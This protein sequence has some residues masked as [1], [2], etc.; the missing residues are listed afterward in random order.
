MTDQSSDPTRVV[1]TR[2]ISFERGL[3][4]VPKHFAR[5]GDVL[6]SH[7]W[8]ML[9]ASFPEGE[10]FFVRSVR[11]YRDQITDP[12]LKR[13]VNGFIGQEASHAREHRALNDRLAELGYP[14]KG[15][16]RSQAWVNRIRERFLSPEANLAATVVAE[17]FTSVLASTSMTDERLQASIDDPVLNGVFAW[18]ALEEIEHKSVAFDVYRAV[19]GSERTRVRTMKLAR[20]FFIGLPIILIIEAVVTDPRAR[21]LRTIRLGIK[22]LR[23]TGL[24]TAETIARLRAFDRPDFHPDQDDTDAALAEW[25]ERL[26]GR[27]GELNDRL[28]AARG[29]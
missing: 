1:P 25:G 3:A 22:R 10:D 14:V 26:F 4:Q 6:A 19:G 8:A 16:E 5:D 28:V 11:H 27:A 2:R 13:Q 9:S 17:H 7:V 23:D 12:A 15:L 21:S 20:K 24:F 18:H 29:A